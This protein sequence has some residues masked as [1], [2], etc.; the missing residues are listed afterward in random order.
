MMMNRSKSLF[1]FSY[2]P[3]I[4]FLGPRAN[5]PKLPSPSKSA[6]NLSYAS[7]GTGPSIKIPSLKYPQLTEEQMELINMGGAVDAPKPK[8]P[9]KK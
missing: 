8:A 5:L 4:K 3:Q 1:Q 6:T 9:K 2:V 7:Y